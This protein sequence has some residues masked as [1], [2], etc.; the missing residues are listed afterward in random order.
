MDHAEA[1]L[2]KAAER[3]VLGDLSV[4]EVEGF[5]RHFFDCPQCSEELRTLSVF[6]ENARA[7]FIEQTSTPSISDSAVSLPTLPLTKP[8]AAGAGW[9]WAAMFSPAV[10]G[11]ALAMLAIAVF[12]GYE[13]GERRAGGPQS[14]NAYPLYAASRGAET[15][16]AP[17]AGAQFFT[18]Y[19]D[20]TWD[21]DYTSYRAV[22]HNQDSPEGSE[23]VSLPL[24][25]PAPGRLIQLLLPARSL[26]PGRYELSILGTDGSGHESK[27]AGYSFTLRFE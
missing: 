4:S 3:Y 16:V 25:A 18:L 27:V 9:S 14:L 22:V 11:P 19:M 20:R 13:F 8:K 7:V 2:M 5:E 23:R 26:A 10:L 1:I 24:P 15:V 12:L 21:R 17:P 6:Q